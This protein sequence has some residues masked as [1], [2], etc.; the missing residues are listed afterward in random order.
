MDESPETMAALQALID[1][2]YSTAGPVIQRGH[3]P[4]WRMSATEFV[5]YWT[6]GRPEGQMSIIGRMAVISTASAT[7]AV[8]AVPLDPI[9]RDGRFYLPTS[10]DSR[11]LRDHFANPRCAISSCD[12]PYRTLV[13]YGTARITNE[14]YRASDGE[15]LILVEVTPTLIYAI[16]PPLGDPRA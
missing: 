9:L 16:R 3:P 11:R 6:E 2:S 1:R 15:E 7:G 8:H 10:R 13:V 14:T 12:G 5:A 4:D